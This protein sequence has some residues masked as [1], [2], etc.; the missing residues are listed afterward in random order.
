MGRFGGAGEV[1]HV[2]RRR[3]RPES[4]L[5]FS[6][7]DIVHRPRL[8][9]SHLAAKQ[10]EMN[11][12]PPYPSGLVWGRRYFRAQLAGSGGRHQ[13][14]RAI[15]EPD[16]RAIRQ[17]IGEIHES[18][19]SAPSPWQAWQCSA[20]QLNP[21]EIAQAMAPRNPSTR[22]SP[23][24]TRHIGRARREIAEAQVLRSLVPDRPPAEAI[25]RAI[26][27]TCGAC[28]S[29]LISRCS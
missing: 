17:R 5:R 10:P 6:A 27:I 28:L 29:S 14:R 21:D 26:G 19:L 8:H 11:K 20:S 24:T 15:D 12:P 18:A 9:D 3:L 13:H 7:C 16:Q 25:T 22:G 23:L 2:V 4:S 1:H